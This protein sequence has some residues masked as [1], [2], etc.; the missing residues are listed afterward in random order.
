MG[1]LTQ[2]KLIS[3]IAQG[4]NATGVLL[5]PLAR[6]E[7]IEWL[8]N[9]I[10]ALVDEPVLPKVGEAARNNG[11]IL[12]GYLEKTKT[13]G[14]P[15]LVVDV[16]RDAP[17][18]SFSGPKYYQVFYVTIRY[19][20]AELASSAPDSEGEYK[21]GKWL[22]EPVKWSDFLEGIIPLPELVIE[23]PEVEEQEAG[24]AREEEKREREVS[25][26][27]DRAIAGSALERARE[28][29]TDTRRG[30]SP[31]TPDLFR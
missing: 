21:D 11:E 29:P 1:V 28:V 3:E 13:E 31:G 25:R 18:E 22:A 12:L 26:E 17:E 15:G 19:E 24:E 16:E 23:E 8:G 27:I 5:S 10:E 6:S 7:I 4:A 9:E 2:S 20:G 30:E 14:S